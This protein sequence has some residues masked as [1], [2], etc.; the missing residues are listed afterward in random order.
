MPES[1]ISAMVAD[2]GALAPVERQTTVL[3]TDLAGFIQMTEK[4]G[5]RGAVA[6][7]NKLVD[8]ATEFIGHT[9]GS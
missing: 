7:I 9:V 1:V 4:A 6:V 2:R 3:F 5:A 8:K